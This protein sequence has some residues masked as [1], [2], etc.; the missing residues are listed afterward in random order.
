MSWLKHLRNISS[1]YCL[2]GHLTGGRSFFFKQKKQHFVQQK[3]FHCTSPRG[4]VNEHLQFADKAFLDNK[5]FFLQKKR[6]T[7][8]VNWDETKT[9]TVLFLDMDERFFRL[10]TF[11]GHLFFVENLRISYNYV[12]QYLYMSV[13]CLVF[14]SNTELKPEF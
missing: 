11:C 2:K 12:H 7:R 6:W 14:F 5:L 13:Y 3:A 9:K 4:L 1:N 8:P 10:Q